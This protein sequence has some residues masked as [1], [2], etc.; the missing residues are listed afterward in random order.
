MARERETASLLPPRARGRR[1]TS[2][3]VA[4]RPTS[5]SGRA[6]LRPGPGIDGRSF[7]S[8]HQIVDRERPESTRDG[9]TP[10]PPRPQAGGCRRL[11]FPH[12]A[13]KTVSSIASLPGVAG[14][15][16]VGR[17]QRLDDDRTRASRRRAVSCRWRTRVNRRL[18][19]G[20]AGHGAAGPLPLD[21]EPSWEAAVMAAERR[22]TSCPCGPTPSGN[23]RASNRPAARS[24]LVPD[25]TL[26]T[27]RF[28]ETA[29]SWSALTAIGAPAP[30]R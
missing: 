7:P 25:P 28:G 14:N 26:H 9:R 15:G 17:G 16:S 19:A 23:W 21:A 5:G 11:S 1:A 3:L 2:E 12:F 24:S 4:A 18:G 10:R 22:S 30:T 6:S 8:P 13:W 20:L 27:V 29:G